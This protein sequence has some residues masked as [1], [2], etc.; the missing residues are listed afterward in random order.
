MAEHQLLAFGR[1]KFS[2]GS[3]LPPT[4]VDQTKLVESYAP[5]SLPLVVPKALDLQLV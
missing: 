3:N 2:H 5:D 1:P 4:E